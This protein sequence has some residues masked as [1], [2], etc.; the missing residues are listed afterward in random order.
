MTPDA[1]P[2]PLT[3][4]TLWA[5]ITDERVRLGD[6]LPGVVVAPAPDGTAAHEVGPCILTR[7]AYETTDRGRRRTVD[8]AEVDSPG[9][10]CHRIE[11]AAGSPP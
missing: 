8:L 1:T 4:A 3:I 5:A 10:R 11:S 9:M 7:V 6:R 2:E